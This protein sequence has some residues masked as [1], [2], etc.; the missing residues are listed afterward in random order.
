[1]YE[2]KMYKE[3][4]EYKKDYSSKL[5]DTVIIGAGITGATAAIY[6]SRKRMNYKLISK[7]FGGQFIIGG[8]I[9]NYPGIIKT[10]GVELSQTLLE[11]MKFNNIDITYEKI[12]GIKKIEEVFAVKTEKTTHMTKTILI[13][14]GSQPR[15]LNILGEK[16][17]MN[18]GVT[19][20]SVCDGPLF[21]D[22]K[23]TIVGGGSSALEAVD[24]LK[25]IA[26]EIKLIVKSDK[27]TGQEYLIENI[28]NN[29]KVEIMYNT[30]PTKI[31]G[32]KSVEKIYI[33][34]EGTEDLY[35]TD[36]VII[37]IGR[38]PNTDL[39][40]DL[41]ELD[42]HNH[43]KIDCSGRTSVPGIFAAG[44][45]ASGHEYQYIIA[46]GQGAHALLKIARYIAN[47]KLN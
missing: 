21:A 31:D 3:N 38:I 41:V 46:A 32:S 27:L 42:E 19:Y 40:K 12:L 22:K 1:M 45:S 29:P 39:V 11:Q 23:V 44:D 10:T 28:I 26:K 18:K 43:I 24:F 15:K 16:E 14:T 47:T 5:L 2:V 36:G 35:D 17:F 7:N 33:N 4:K 13:A 30:T 20:C 9:L 34:K 6:A 37:E 8:E 25:D